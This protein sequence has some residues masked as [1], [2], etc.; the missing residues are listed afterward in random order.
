LAGEAAAKACIDV[1][2]SEDGDSS[3]PTAAATPSAT[4]TGNKV[5]A[6]RLLDGLGGDTAAFGSSK[7]SGGQRGSM[8]NLVAKEGVDADKLPQVAPAPQRGRLA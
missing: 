2:L 6:Q 5:A 8:R 7:L 1:C 4:A 3:E